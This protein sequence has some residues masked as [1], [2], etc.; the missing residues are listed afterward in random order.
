[1]TTSRIESLRIKAKLLQKAKSR[2]G[3]ACALKDAFAIIARHS[4]FGSWQKMKATIEVH[5]SLR[6]A[7]AAS[8]WNI[9][10]GTYA[11]GKAHVRAQGEFLLPY[12]RQCFVCDADYIANLGLRLDDPDLIAVG[13]DWVVP[14]NQGA[15][16]RLL[17]KLRSKGAQS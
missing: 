6:P 2:A 13:N 7:H 15:W 5:E 16:N 4:G 14:A 17:G 12:Q 3:K 11:E 9:W 10:Y 8:L 1:M